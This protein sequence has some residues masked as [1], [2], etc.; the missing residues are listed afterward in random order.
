[1]D[2]RGSWGFPRV[3]WSDDAAKAARQFEALEEVPSRTSAMLK[4][5]IIRTSRIGL[6]AFLML[7]VNFCYAGDSTKA[8]DEAAAVQWLQSSAHPFSTASPTMEEMQPLVAALHG[9]EVIGIGEA[10][11]GSHE[12]ESFKADL[13]KALILQGRVD[14]F[15]LEAN[16]QIGADLD[17]Y[18]T[19]QG[20][21]LPTLLR[22]PSLFRNL[23]NEEFAGLIL[24]IRAYNIQ[25]NHPVHVVGIDCQDGGIDAEFAL[26]FVKARDAKIAARFDGAFTSLLAGAVRPRFAVWVATANASD[27]AK[28]NEASRKLEQLFSAHQATWSDKPGY[29]EAAYAAKTARQAFDAFELDGGRG[30]PEKNGM[31][32]YGRR[33]RYMAANLLERLNGRTGVF[34]AHDMHVMADLPATDGWPSG[35]TWVGREVHKVLGEQYQTV[36]F[37]WSKGSF[38]SQTQK[39]EQNFEV[40]HRK[41]MVPQTLPNDG[42]DDLGG[43]LIRTGFD[44]FWVDLRTLPVQPWARRFA[45]TNYAR[46]W[47]GWRVDAKTWNKDVSDRASLRPASDILVWFKQITPSHMF[48]GDDF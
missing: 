32:Y 20:G 2:A 19:G 40:T 5:L 3:R 29:A 28:A 17:A 39:G 4:R 48:P 11:H 18:V 34:W 15:F 21:D 14:V 24:W 7:A 47:A 33:D 8:A 45:S 16:R 1:M 13:I 6:V 43:V 12:D 27:Y 38:L 36:T 35:F 31:A 42:P 26:R 10:T 25:T 23:R 44:G 46:G 22:S 30:N 9:A 37:A 41:P